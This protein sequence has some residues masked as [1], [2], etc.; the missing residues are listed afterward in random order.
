MTRVI[1][2]I[3]IIIIIFICFILAILGGKITT[4]RPLNIK[5]SKCATHAYNLVCFDLLHE[6]CNMMYVLEKRVMFM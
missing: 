6:S 5:S 2:I 1:I 4:I 3:I